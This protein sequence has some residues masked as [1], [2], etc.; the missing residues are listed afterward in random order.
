MLQM[1]V[2]LEEKWRALKAAKTAGARTVLNLVPAMLIDD[3]ILADLDIL[4]VNQPEAQFIGDFIETVYNR[5][6]LHSALNYLSPVEFEG[7]PFPSAVM[8]Q[9]KGMASTNRP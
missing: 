1:E 4:I 6:R 9:Q 3:A 8:V 7:R 5:Q 2:P